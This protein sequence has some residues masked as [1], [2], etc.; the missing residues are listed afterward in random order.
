MARKGYERPVLVGGGAVEFHTGGAVV[1]GDFD[2]VT[3]EMRAFGE[4]LA[5]H[6]FKREDRPGRLLIGWYHPELTMGVQVVSGDL[7]DG[8]SDR[9][10][11]RLV[12]IIDGK[13][14]AIA[15]IEDLIADRLGQ[16]A[17][18]EAGMPDRLDQ[19]VKLFRLADQLDEAYLDRRIR[20]ETGGIFDLAY[21]KR[22][23][24]DSDHP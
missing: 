20:Q 8:N 4:V 10:R 12:D 22:Q 9:R 18:T 6:G 1:S 15:S 11:I 14:V 16:H 24:D 5:A 3:E 13:A 17:S 23:I 2:F 21:L 7:F 19:A